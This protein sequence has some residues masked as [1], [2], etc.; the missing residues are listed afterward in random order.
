[1]R[2]I[3]EGKPAEPM[4]PDAHKILKAMRI[5]LGMS[6]TETAKKVG[7][8]LCVYSKYENVSGFRS[9]S[10]LT[11]PRRPWKPVF[12]AMILFR[13]SCAIGNA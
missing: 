3:I 12:S 11:L 9:A 13:T 6:Q 1:M 4:N 2:R 7:I 8:S 5:Y 10:L